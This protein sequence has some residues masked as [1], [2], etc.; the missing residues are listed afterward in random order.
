M[1]LLSKFTAPPEAQSV[2]AHSWESCVTS[3]RVEIFELEMLSDVKSFMSSTKA[4]I[5]PL[6]KSLSVGS[7][8]L[9]P[10]AF[11]RYVFRSGSHV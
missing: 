10:C 8:S 7:F 5:D 4:F 3:L 2:F 9:C 11:E 1:W 6:V